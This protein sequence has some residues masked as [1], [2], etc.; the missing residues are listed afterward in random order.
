MGLPVDRILI[1]TLR[2]VPGNYGV[3][4]LVRHVAR[5]APA[6]TSAISPLALLQF[7]NLGSFLQGTQHLELR[8]VLEDYLAEVDIHEPVS[9]REVV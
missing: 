1:G 7:R 4:Q 9:G 3:T 8:S 6:A 2:P 5:M